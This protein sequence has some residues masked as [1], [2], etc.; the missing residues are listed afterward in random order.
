MS[1]VFKAFES[2]VLSGNVREV[3][4]GRETEDKTGRLG[5]ARWLNI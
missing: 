2:V 1:V 5:K 3:E 4:V